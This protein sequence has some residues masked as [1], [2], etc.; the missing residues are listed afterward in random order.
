MVVRLRGAA[1]GVE[2]RGVPS[3]DISCSVEGRS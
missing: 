1:V 3:G 2:D